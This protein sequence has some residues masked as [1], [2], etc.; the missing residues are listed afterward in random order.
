MSAWLVLVVGVA[1]VVLWFVSRARRYAALFGAPHL[2]EV[3]R[4]LVRAKAAALAHVIRD[5][6]DAPAA[7]DDAR[8]LTTSAGLAIVYTV[9]ERPPGFVH[10]CSV[11]VIGGP[12][13]HAVGG[14]FLMFVTKRLGLQ[15]AGLQCCVE[16]STVHHA[17]LSVDAAR[18][19][20]LAAEPIPELTPAALPDLHREALEAR[21]RV[22]WARPNIEADATPR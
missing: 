22:T 18:H 10:H 14:L 6:S 13:P 3:G 16:A 9:S 7:A 17:E 1:L 11:S 2:L 4:G 19:A 12:T 8:I 20:Q 21:D 5:D 15:Q